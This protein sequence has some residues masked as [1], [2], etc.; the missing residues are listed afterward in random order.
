MFNDATATATSPPA[1]VQSKQRA[2]LDGQLTAS[3]WT[4]RL[5]MAEA[6][7]STKQQELELYAKKQ[8]FNV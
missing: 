8:K 7:A 2:V 3:W 4:D 5:T 1:A 6:C